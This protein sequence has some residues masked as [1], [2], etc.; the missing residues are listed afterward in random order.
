MSRQTSG[1][2]Y[3]LYCLRVTSPWSLPYLR[4]TSG[5]ADVQLSVASSPLVTETDLAN[6]VDA[7][8]SSWFNRRLLKDGSI[9]L[10]YTDLFEFLISNDGSRVTCCPLKRASRESFQTYLLSQAFSYALLKKCIEPLHS[11]AVVINGRAVGFLG[12]SGAGKS[13]LAATFLRAGHRLLTDDLLIAKD[14]I[15]SFTVFPGPR[16]IKLLPDMSAFLPGPTY[17][18]RRMNHLGAKLIFPLRAQ[19][20]QSAPVPLTALYLLSPP[21]R[22]LTSRQ[23]RITRLSE[24]QALIELLRNTYNS[25]LTDQARLKRQFSWASRVAATIPVKRLAYRRD[26]ALLPSVY[27][28]L[29]TDLGY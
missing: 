10:Q 27:A 3:E 9:Y 20:W 8:S 28:A 21:P 16:K 15:A 1:S 26:G 11:T 23:V 4:R 7:A 24:R 29:L 19:Y 22:S 25:A 13:S 6:S 18:A 14:G 17:R 5:P 2:Q 12:G